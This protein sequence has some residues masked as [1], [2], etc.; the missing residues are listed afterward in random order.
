MRDADTPSSAPAPTRDRLLEAATKVFLAQGFTAASM[1]MVRQEAGVSNGSLYH[2]FPTKALLADALY[3]HTLRDFHAALTAPIAGKASA[4]A[5][6]KGLL[7]AYIQWVLQH[8][9]QA[10]LLH[11]LRRGGGV[12]DGAEINAANEQAFGA[13]K[14]WMEQRMEAGEM[15]A[16]PFHL[17]MALVFSPAMSLTQRWASQPA[18]AVAPKVRAA[19]EHAAWMAVAP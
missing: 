18:P 19:L 8:P 4:Q 5:G 14:A 16:M 15:R 7:R 6:V 11:A 9:E 10:Q 13:L 3:A 2:H 1:D 12:T 17:W